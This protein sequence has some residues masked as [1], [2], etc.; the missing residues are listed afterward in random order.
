M[1]VQR[2]KRPVEF[3]NETGAEI[4][5]DEQSVVRSIVY[6]QQP[7]MLVGGKTAHAA[8]ENYLRTHGSVLGLDKS[9]LTALGH[10]SQAHLIDRG[11]EYRFAEEKTHFNMSTVVFEQTYL[12]LPIWQA[13]IAVHVKRQHTP[14]NPVARI[15]HRA[16][17]HVASRTLSAPPIYQVISY[18]STR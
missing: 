12:G 7:K 14:T 5:R 10:P 16:R 11:V 13:G 9:Q 6:S 18:Q 15:W 3:D 2:G 8:A 17:H 4:T 1:R